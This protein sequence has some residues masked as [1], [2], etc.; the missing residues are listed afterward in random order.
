MLKAMCGPFIYEPRE[1]K[2]L[3]A[4]RRAL[5]PTLRYRTFP[6]IGLG[7]LLCGSLYSFKGN[8]DL[9]RG[10]IRHNRSILRSLALLRQLSSAALRARLFIESAQ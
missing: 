9:V 3:A 4:V 7:N 10:G 1:L 2:D 6:G 5:R 8:K